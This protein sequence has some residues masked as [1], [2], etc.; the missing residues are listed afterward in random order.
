[1]RGK[2]YLGSAPAERREEG[3]YK[4]I[5]LE[6]KRF[7]FL[8]KETEAKGEKLTCYRWVS[9]EGWHRTAVQG[10]GLGDR[11]GLSLRRPLPRCVT[12]DEL[13]KLGVLQFPRAEN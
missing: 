11:Q 5:S 10:R 12:S 2:K 3:I 13:L 9:Q 4:M 8:D 1:M 6:G 7:F